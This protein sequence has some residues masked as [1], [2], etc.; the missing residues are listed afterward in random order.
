MNSSDQYTQV[1]AK[2]LT[3]GVQI[4]IL[5]FFAMDFSLMVTVLKGCHELTVEIVNQV[6]ADKLTEPVTEITIKSLGEGVGLMSSIARAE[7]SES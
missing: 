6:L 7:L 5:K 2:R 3:L 1:N 4:F